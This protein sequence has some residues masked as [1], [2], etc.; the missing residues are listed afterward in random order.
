MFSI[1]SLYF[2]M[3]LIVE[4]ITTLRK[5][6][7]SVSTPVRCSNKWK[8]LMAHFHCRLRNTKLNDIEPFVFYVILYKMKSVK[9]K[10]EVIWLTWRWT[11]RLLSSTAIHALQSELRR[12]IGLKRIHEIRRKQ[13]SV[14]I[15]HEENHAKIRAQME[16]LT[17]CS[18]DE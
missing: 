2:L 12:D 11:G 5:I 10:K 14:L 7:P 4:K 17:Y 15:R 16:Y 9:T 3:N 1:L 13:R 6:M 18:I 8:S